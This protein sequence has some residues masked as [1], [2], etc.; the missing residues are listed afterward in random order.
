MP[1]LLKFLASIAVIAGLIY[2][3]MF[4]LV[5]MVEPDRREMS[6]RVPADRLDPQPITAPQTAPLETGAADT[7]DQTAQ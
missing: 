6:V 2:G 7:G 3:A 5:T 1:S 4:G